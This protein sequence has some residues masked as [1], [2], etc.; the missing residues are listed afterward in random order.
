MEKTKLNIKKGDEVKVLSGKDKGK[1]GKI[2]EV[3]P[4]ARRVVVEGLNIRVR[5][6]RPKRRNEKGQRME[7]PAPMDV[8]KLMLVCP[9]CSKP[10]RVGRSV[11]EKG[12]F[13]MCRKCG[14]TLN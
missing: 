13:R 14:K 7:L 5:F 8:S 2:L 1:T 11:S 12:N 9:H 6:S 3:I 4:S 10:T